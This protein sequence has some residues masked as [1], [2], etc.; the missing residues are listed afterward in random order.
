M[1]GPQEPSTTPSR[2]EPVAIGLIGTGEIARILL[3]QLADSSCRFVSVT[4]LNRDAAQAFAKDHGDLRV[5]DSVDA[6]A[7]AEDI[8]AVFV[9]TPPGSH[10]PLIEQ[11][12]GHGKH[13]LC[14]KPLTTGPDEALALREFEAAHPDLKLACCSSRFRCTPSARVAGEL[15][16]GG[17]LGALRDVRLRASVSLPRPLDAVP[18][19]RRK[20]GAGGLVSDWCVYELEWLRGVFGAAFDPVSVHAVTDDFGR[21]GMGVDSGYHVTVG[22][23]SGAFVR[24]T[25]I[26]EIGPRQHG[27]ELRW[28]RGGLDVPFAPDAQDLSIHE[29]RAGEEGKIETTTHD[30]SGPQWGDILIGPLE[31][32]ARA[33][34]NE[35]SLLAPIGTQVVVQAAI[36]AIQESA[37]TGRV[38]ELPSAA[39]G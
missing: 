19:W 8:D 12:V 16:R 2:S 5:E 13:V 25:R 37:A 10:R 18:E 1:P 9:A 32:F 31:N 20:P 29:Y 27:V 4:D 24:L 14:E 26:A 7:A 28:E 33:V 6:L 34:R 23:G 21:E 11:C 35:E 15:H 36:H 3:P 22:C 30:A 39:I 38:V 17:E